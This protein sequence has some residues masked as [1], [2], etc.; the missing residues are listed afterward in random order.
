MLSSRDLSAKAAVG[1]RPPTQDK[2]KTEKIKALLLCFYNKKKFSTFFC[3]LLAKFDAGGNRPQT[4][5]LRTSVS[6]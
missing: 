2:K 6:R 4:Q 3:F 5:E 1:S